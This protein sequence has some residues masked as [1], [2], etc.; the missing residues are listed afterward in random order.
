[1]LGTCIQ[2]LR[3]EKGFT[4]SQLAAKTQISKSYLSHIERNIQSNP[5]IEVLMK[6]AFA[7]EVDIQTL[8]MT[9]E[10]EIS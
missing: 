3:Q 6:I 4:L 9:K 2:R 7:L 8:I 1:M 5:S 10:N